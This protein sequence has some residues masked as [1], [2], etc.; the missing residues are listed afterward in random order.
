MKR[1]L[2]I[3]VGV[4]LLAGLALAAG[5]AS[6]QKPMA[7]AFDDELAGAPN[8]VKIGGNA[9]KKDHKD[10]PAIYGVGSITGTKNISLARTGATAR[11]RTELAR[12]L[13]THVKAMIADYQRTTTGGEE[14]GKAAADEQDLKDVAK[15]VT[16]QTLAGT[17]LVDTWISKNSTFYALVSLDVEKF[18][19]MVSNMKTLSE[20]IRKA[21]Q[22]RAD[23]AFS[24]LDQEIDKNK[25]APAAN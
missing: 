12:S 16:D 24:E 11:A 22:A 9:Y 13:E 19:S 1:M 23:K 15:Q 18:K 8:W 5:C 6:A 7:Q 4:L 21:V 20:G 25:Q 3:A 2:L 10:A 14:F 17:E